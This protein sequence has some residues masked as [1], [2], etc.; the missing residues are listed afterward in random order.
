MK[1]ITVV[2]ISILFVSIFLGCGSPNEEIMKL[3]CPSADRNYIVSFYHSAGGGAAGV[4]DEFAVL[5]RASEHYNSN[6]SKLILRMNRGYKVHILW[7]NKTNIVIEY[8]QTATADK[9]QKSVDLDRIFEIKYIPKPS[10]DGRFLEDPG[11]SC[12]EEDQA[13]PLEQ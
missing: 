3:Q 10:R 7:T 8:P 12:R 13:M 9:F 6:D 4:L 11:C 5:H 1:M 2:C